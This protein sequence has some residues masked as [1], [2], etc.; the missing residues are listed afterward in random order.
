MNIPSREDIARFV[1]PTIFEAFDSIKKDYEGLR[2]LNADLLDE[3]D[4][5]ESKLNAKISTLQAQLD[6]SIIKPNFY[7]KTFTKVENIRY[8]QKRTWQ[9]IPIDCEINQFIQPNQF[10]VQRLRKKIGAQESSFYNRVYSTAVYVSKNMTWTDDKS[11]A[12]SGDYYLYPEEIIVSKKGDCE[13]HAFLMASLVEGVNV[14]YGF[15][16]QENGD[17][18]GH[19]FNVFEENGIIYIIDTVGDVPEVKVYP[20]KNFEIYFIITDLAT[21]KLKGGVSFGVLAEW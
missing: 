8:K 3:N 18:F 7:D 17:K 13:D 10:E 14:A 21:Y 20:D 4:K 5:R 2:E 1:Y 11:L 9:K 12:A 6:A 19:A 16:L 15:Y